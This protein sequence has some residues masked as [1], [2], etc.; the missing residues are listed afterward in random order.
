VA[1]GNGH[2]GAEC[3]Q[4]HGVK[5][6]VCRVIWM[7]HVRVASRGQAVDRTWQSLA[8]KRT[9]AHWLWTAFA[10][11]LLWLELKTLELH[12]C[13]WF[14]LFHASAMAAC[15]LHG[16]KKAHQHRETRQDECLILE[17]WIFLSL[18]RIVRLGVMP[19]TCEAPNIASSAPRP[20]GLHDSRHVKAGYKTLKHAQTP[21]VQRI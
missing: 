3:N 5:V 12:S 2:W 18:M 11:K 19:V 6:H 9:L 7:Y 17:A 15:A 14:E 8:G 16:D 20:P 21:L 13:F 4:V 10:C 1:R